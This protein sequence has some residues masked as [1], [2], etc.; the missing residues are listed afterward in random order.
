MRHKKTWLNPLG[1]EWIND[2]VLG[3]T[4]AARSEFYQP[5]NLAQTMFATAYASVGSST[6]YLFDQGSRSPNTAA[7]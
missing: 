4:N 2:V 5:L 6:E 7:R 3:T 1:G